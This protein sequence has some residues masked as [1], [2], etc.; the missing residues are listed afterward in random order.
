M[1]M[2]DEFICICRCGVAFKAKGW[3]TVNVT[4]NP[5]YNNMI[6]RGE[7]NY[8]KCPECGE[9]G[10]INS[11]FLYHDMMKNIMVWVYPE[12]SKQQEDEI[13][14]WNKKLEKMMINS[15]PNRTPSHKTMTV[16]GI[17][18]L[19]KMIEDDNF[20][21][22]TDILIPKTQTMKFRVL[23][24][25]KS[26]YED[27]NNNGELCYRQQN[28][29]KAAANFKLAVEVWDESHGKE[30]LAA[31]Y[32]S[33]GTAL[34]NLGKHEEAI[35]K[36]RKAAEINPKDGTIYS[37]WGSVL[38]NIDKNEEAIDKY[39]KA[40]EINPGYAT[41]YYNWG[42]AL[43]NLGRYEEAKEKYR[44]ARDLFKEQGH[45]HYIAA[46]ESINRLK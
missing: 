22:P 3:R 25:E 18:I 27:Y 6:L 24:Y 39:R 20:E 7:F 43:N 36:Y 45:P 10:Y 30:N 1:S 12:E 4:L 38:G 9:V 8:A 14:E 37:N 40:T 28:Y 23:E 26:E 11:Y 33:W 34:E 31:A 21:L 13:I 19:K 41:A 35:E 2:Q 16:F 42:N 29:E 15:I 32:S 46:E 44:K 17:D 5:N